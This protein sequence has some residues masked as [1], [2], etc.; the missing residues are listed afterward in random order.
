MKCYLIVPALAFMGLAACS[1]DMSAM[2]TPEPPADA[3]SVAAPIGSEGLTH[4][5][6]QL[7]AEEIQARREAWVGRAPA[8]GSRVAGAPTPS[9][10]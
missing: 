8:V 9:R 4:V 6:D 5:P 7:T 3:E 1:K 10:E 2:A